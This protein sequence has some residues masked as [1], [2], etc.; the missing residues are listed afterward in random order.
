MGGERC[1]KILTFWCLCLE[2]S[3]YL[4][5]FLRGFLLFDYSALNL[6]LFFF[7]C[8]WWHFLFPGRV[9][10]AKWLAFRSNRVFFF[11][12]HTVVPSS[13][14]PTFLPLA[15]FL[16]L[17][18]AHSWQLPIELTCSFIPPH[19]RHEFNVVQHWNR[20]NLGSVTPKFIYVIT[21][22]CVYYR[23]VLSVF[24]FCAHLQL[25]LLK[26]KDIPRDIASVVTDY[27]DKYG[28]PIVLP[29]AYTIV[30]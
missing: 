17:M 18:D 16:E 12:F 28:R 11:L 19:T 27:R 10:S 9:I 15:S 7:V 20:S 14:P 25:G 13:Q 3:L 24:P 30:L 29:A 26:K 1:G 8:W 22:M 4:F 21:A 2:H 5:L 6:V 23:C